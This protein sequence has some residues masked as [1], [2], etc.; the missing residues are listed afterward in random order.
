MLCVDFVMKRPKHLR[1][2]LDARHMTKPDSD[3]LDRSTRDALTQAGVW[4]DDNRV[5]DAHIS[6][7]YEGD[8]NL[9]AIW[10]NATG[11]WIRIWSLAEWNANSVA[12]RAA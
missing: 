10:A 3:K 12:T 11:A 2:K 6:K 7:R 5:V 1:N 8:P 9:P 4:E